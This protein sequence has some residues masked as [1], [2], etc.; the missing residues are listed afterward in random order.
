MLIFHL[1]SYCYYYYCLC[2]L[3]IQS[4]HSCSHFI[5]RSKSHDHIWLQGR[6][7]AQSNMCQKEEHWAFGSSPNDYHNDYH[8]A[9]TKGDERLHQ[10]RLIISLQVHMH[11][12][13][14]SLLLK[15]YKVSSR[16]MNREWLRME[17]ILAQRNGEENKTRRKEEQK[18]MKIL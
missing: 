6:W 1:K 10:N 14:H 8:T 7:E 18:Q 9:N 3:L 13:G 2:M 12:S 11:K 16:K 4:H 15:Y 5:G 17:L